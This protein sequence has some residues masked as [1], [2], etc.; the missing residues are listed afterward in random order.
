MFTIALFT[1]SISTLHAESMVKF[2]RSTVVGRKTEH[3]YSGSKIEAENI[4]FF[5]TFFPGKN[6]KFASLEPPAPLVFIVY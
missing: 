1:L 3:P 5:W 2:I 6:P 4:A